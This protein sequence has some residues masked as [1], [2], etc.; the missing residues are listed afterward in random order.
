MYQMGRA[1][2]WGF[3]NLYDGLKNKNK[4]SSNNASKKIAA[5]ILMR[6]ILHLN[7]FKIKQTVI[8]KIIDNI[9]YIMYFT[10]KGGAI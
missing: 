1:T 10:K 7:L 8:L 2:G 5:V 6:Q 4:Q 3:S 9:F